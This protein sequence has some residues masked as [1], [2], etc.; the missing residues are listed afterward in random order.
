[1]RCL[2][3]YKYVLLLL[4]ALNLVSVALTL[5]KCFWFISPWDA[6]LLMQRLHQKKKYIDRQMNVQFA[7]CKYSCHIPFTVFFCDKPLSFCCFW[8]FAPMS[9]L[10]KTW[11]VNDSCITSSKCFEETESNLPWPWLETWGEEAF[12]GSW[13]EA[14]RALVRTGERRWM[15]KCSEAQKF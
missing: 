4:S 11:A 2:L 14:P 3:A 1:M 8:L 6:V 12:C 13:Q 7:I 9:R 10:T 15:T 5:K